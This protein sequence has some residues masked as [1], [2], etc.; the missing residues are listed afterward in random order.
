MRLRVPRTPRR[1]PLRTEWTTTAGRNP[2]APNPTAA[3]Y[4]KGPSIPI[5]GSS[6]SVSAQRFQTKPRM[7][8]RSSSGSNRDRTFAVWSKRTTIASNIAYST[9]PV[10]NPTRFRSSPTFKVVDTVRLWLDVAKQ[11]VNDRSSSHNQRVVLGHEWQ[12]SSRMPLSHYAVHLPRLMT[13]PFGA[14][15][16]L[17]RSVRKSPKRRVRSPAKSGHPLEGIGH[18]LGS[19]RH[20]SQD[21]L[22][23][24][25]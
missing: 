7:D 23:S 17:A 13:R 8:V 11:E 12:A 20:R 5:F 4:G 15:D 2:R 18:S 16:T 1:S 25:L 6:Y 21:L 22:P 10:L 19:C 14:S 24:S 9:T 3:T